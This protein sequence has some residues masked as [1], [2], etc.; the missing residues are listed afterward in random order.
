MC[1]DVCPP[2]A[3]CCET[4]EVRC[5]VWEHILNVGLFAEDRLRANCELTCTYWVTVLHSRF[6]NVDSKPNSNWETARRS[7][8]SLI[9]GRTELSHMSSFRYDFITKLC[10]HAKHSMPLLLVSIN[11]KTQYAQSKKSV[12][13][14][15]GRQLDWTHFLNKWL[16]VAM[17]QMSCRYYCWQK[18]IARGG[19]GPTQHKFCKSSTDRQPGSWERAKTTPGGPGW[20]PWT[21]GA[22]ALEAGAADVELARCG[23]VA[24]CLSATERITTSDRRWRRSTARCRNPFDW[25][26]MHPSTSNGL[27]AAV[28]RITQQIE[29]AASMF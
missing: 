21:R 22:A 19:E 23:N 6:A 10:N 9:V 8:N 27:V 15:E 2:A 14:R 28:R 26:W 12:S 7:Y 4:S 13:Y 11:I 1:D 25:Q 20:Q 18:G 24:A 3:R 29:V 5:V 16:M 17:V